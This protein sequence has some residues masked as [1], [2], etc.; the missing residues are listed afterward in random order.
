MA[1]AATVPSSTTAVSTEPSTEPMFGQIWMYD[2]SGPYMILWPNP[3]ADDVSRAGSAWFFMDCD[4][5]Y[6]HTFSGFF[7]GDP[8]KRLEGYKRVDE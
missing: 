1:N 5:G 2:H 7:G 4:D 8:E 3:E 6:L